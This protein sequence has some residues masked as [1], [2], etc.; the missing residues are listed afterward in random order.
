[1]NMT[2]IQL[3][4]SFQFTCLEVRKFEYIS[5]NLMVGGKTVM[6]ITNEKMFT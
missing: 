2:F 3:K 6:L 4:L 1:M 5:L